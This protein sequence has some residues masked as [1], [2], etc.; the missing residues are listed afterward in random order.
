MKVIKTFTDAFNP[1]LSE[2]LLHVGRSKPPRTASPETHLD[3]LGSK[4]NQPE[5][6]CFSVNFDSSFEFFEQLHLP[7]FITAYVDPW[8]LLCALDLV[9]ETL[10]ALGTIDIFALN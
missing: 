2:Y 3:R 10:R 5:P 4:C 9:F 6:P 1:I 7:I 8:P